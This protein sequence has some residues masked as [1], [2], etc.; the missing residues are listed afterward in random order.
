MVFGVLAQHEILEA[1]LD[2]EVKVMR[3][4]FFT[5]CRVSINNHKC[6]EK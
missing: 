3:Q 5:T 4:D 6:T 2:K 1:I